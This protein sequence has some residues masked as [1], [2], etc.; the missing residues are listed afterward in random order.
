MSLYKSP[1]SPILNDTRYQAVLD[2]ETHIC[3][4]QNKYQLLSSINFNELTKSNEDINLELAKQILSNIITL[5]NSNIS[6]TDI[7]NFLISRIVDL[8]SFFAFDQDIIN[9][10]VR[11]IYFL[12]SLDDNICFNYVDET[13]I[14]FLFKVIDFFLNL[15]SIMLSFYC[16]SE[17]TN[18]KKTETRNKLNG[19]SILQKTLQFVDSFQNYAYCDQFKNKDII[20]FSFDVILN[21]LI[22][23]NFDLE[24]V[25]DFI[26][27]LN[28]YLY[29]F[30]QNNESN[31]VEKKVHRLWQISSIQTISA[32]VSCRP[33]YKGYFIS[34]EMIDLLIKLILSDFDFEL[35]ELSTHIFCTIDNLSFKN[36][37]FSFNLI[38]HDPYLLSFQPPDH[39]GIKAKSYFCR[40][41][42]TPIGNI[43]ICKRLNLYK[44]YLPKAVE[45]L[46]K[47]AQFLIPLMTQYIETA[48]FKLRKVASIVLCQFINLNDSKILPLATL[49]YEEII[50]SLIFLLEDNINSNFVIFL[51]KS[52]RTLCHYGEMISYENSKP[53]PFL[54]LVLN[55]NILDTL[56]NIE[57]TYYDSPEVMRNINSFRNEIDNYK[58]FREIDQD[59][60]Q[61]IDDIIIF[62]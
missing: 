41:I 50:E 37:V 18:N 13:V 56:S 21:C 9:L 48:D 39:W 23:Y 20:S 45:I 2:I 26:H 42:I 43:S 32:V 62:H 47:S 24:I 8:S 59:Q 60:E 29:L 16:L 38:C 34:D 11:I 61:G 36:D 5:L 1:L 25:E 15:N 33:A 17:F 51:I 49:G 44:E 52:L 35:E 7:P 53:N 30:S 46:E 10:S 19:L 4:D 6:I 54:D 40:A 22:S 28:R 57:T 14:D 31:E 58:Y 12:C 3:D 27:Q 55:L